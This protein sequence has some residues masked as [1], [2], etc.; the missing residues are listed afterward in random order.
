MELLIHGDF[1]N[2]VFHK[3]RQ[4]CYP[5]KKILFLALDRGS[6][7][8]EIDIV[9]KIKMKTCFKECTNCHYKWFD[10]GVFL[11]DPAVELVGYQ[12]N[13]G[14]LQ[15]GFFL[16]NHSIRDCGTSFAVEAGRFTDMHDGPIFESRAK[17]PEDC[18]GYCQDKHKL[19][20]CDTECECAYVRDVL[21]KVKSWP[22]KLDD[23]RITS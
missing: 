14:K 16:F 8:G 11:S 7:D 1:T 2:P 3:S 17:V 10:R 13:Y 21:Q 19:D 6:A 15:A 22:K 20:A 9:E 5:V 12:V 23:A 4:S 18:P